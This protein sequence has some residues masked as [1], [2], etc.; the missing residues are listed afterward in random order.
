[1]V[2]VKMLMRMMI[3]TMIGVLVMMKALISP[4]QREVSL[5]EW[6]CRSSRLLLPRFHL[7]TA[8]LCPE[9]YHF[10]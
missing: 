2:L 5:A 6:L 10:F 9:N 3:S 8:A 1:M 7:E 4:S